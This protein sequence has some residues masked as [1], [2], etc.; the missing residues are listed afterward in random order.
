MRTLSDA[1]VINEVR[2]EQPGYLAGLLRLL[3]AE[4]D[5]WFLWLPVFFG[6]GI[7]LYMGLEAE[8]PFAAAVAPAL[9][10]LALVAAWRAGPF[11]IPLGVGL[12]AIACG[13]AATKLRTELVRAPVLERQ[14]YRVDVAG[15]IERVEPRQTRGPRV[16]LAVQ[17]VGRLEPAALPHRVRVRFLRAAPGLAPGQPVQ[18]KAT[19]APPARPSLPGDFDFARTA[20]YQGIGGVGFAMAPPRPA[21][22]LGSPPVWLQVRAWI[23]RRRQHIG[24]RVRA[25][26]AG[27]V[28][29]LANA[30]MTGERGGVSQ[31]TMDAYR[32]A[33][34]LHILAISGL[35]MAIMAGSVFVFLRF[36]L[37][38]IPALALRYPIKKWAAA[39]A[40]CAALAY[41][42]VSGSSFATIRAFIMILVMLLA[43]MLDRPA[44]ALRNVAI[45]GLAIMIFVPESL[46][47][48]GFQMSFAAV[49]ALVAAYEAWADRRRRTPR[50]TVAPGLFGQIGLFIVGIIAST[51]IA[52]IAVAP[53]AAFHFHQSQQLA[54][55]AN[56]IA[57]PVCNVIVMPAALA[58]FVAMPFGLEAIPL[59][60][61]GRGIEVMTW[62]AK[63]VAGL[64]GAVTRVPAFPVHTFALIVLGGLWL[65]IWRR[66]WRLFGCVAVVAGI[67]VAPFMTRPDALVGRE[68]RLVAVRAPDGRLAALGGR[69]GAYELRRWLQHD[70]DG[71]SVREARRAGPY[72]CDEAGCTAMVKKVL[73]AV[74]RH[75]RA[76]ADDCRRAGLLVLRFPKP[77]GCVTQAPVIDFF[78]LRREGT[79]AVFVDDGGD[80]RIETVAA[81]RGD[82]PWSQRRWRRRP[83]S[84]ARR[85]PASAD[86]ARV[87]RFAPR[88]PLE[89]GS[90]EDHWRP[91]IEGDEDFGWDR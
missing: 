26:L 6:I 84:A 16:T 23:E 14:I 47:N 19:L 43:V 25:A 7:A 59:W 51:V 80:I 3:E 88:L 34:I 53:F 40:A 72:R 44:I 91:E 55:L 64:P 39:A 70:G 12:A 4:R 52:G 49:V 42:M 75:P 29:G 78:A 8:P 45:A 89:T 46:F 48:V 22:E 50:T 87:G 86:A 90:D 73:F 66:R 65:C 41:L 24:E 81:A 82:R 21:P 10:A 58:A 85:G 20:F 37:A 17:R 1:E 32:D 63:T 9:A 28:G 68:G 57:V 71:R 38:C 79:H 13:V 74:S 56:L 15:F 2:E 18:F 30:L 5:R 35:H 76:L 36:L 61:M 83:R 31:T 67:A 33:G 62:T 60:V 27:E 11:A 69:T 77:G 54:V